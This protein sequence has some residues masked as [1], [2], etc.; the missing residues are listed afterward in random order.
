MGTPQGN[1]SDNF[2]STQCLA[3]IQSLVNQKIGFKFHLTSGLFSCSFDNN[4]TVTATT[5][6]PAEARK[7]TPSTKRRNAKRRRLFLER[8]KLGSSVDH[9]SGPSAN[10]D[11]FLDKNIQK[12]S[13]EEGMVEKIPL[14]LNPKAILPKDLESSEEFEDSSSEEGECNAEYEVGECSDNVTEADNARA[15]LPHCVLQNCSV[16][17][18]PLDSLSH[19]VYCSCS[20]SR[21]QRDRMQCEKGPT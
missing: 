6:T 20:V 18:W 9:D 3:L 7:K 15:A 12:A 19:V 13:R 2:L 17:G 21:E 4:G 11:N 5:L 8:K 14:D 1:G 16:S 10:S